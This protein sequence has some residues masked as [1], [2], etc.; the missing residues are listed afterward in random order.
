MAAMAVASATARKIA[1]FFVEA[2]MYEAAPYIDT[3]M[4]MDLLDYFR[5][6]LPSKTTNMFGETASV[7]SESERSL[8]VNVGKG[9]ELEYGLAVSG[10][11]SLLV[12]IE[13]LPTPM[14]DSKV[15]LFGTG[16]KVARRA[17]VM[18]APSDWLTDEGRANIESVEL[19]VPF[20]TASAKFVEDGNKLVFTNTIG[21]YYSDK[22]STASEVARYL[23]PQ[24]TYRFNGKTFVPAK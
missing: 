24:I 23:K 12:V 11:D 3:N 14:P 1:D 9:V 17:S 6:N 16:W 5:S 8:L 4:R 13:T 2:P 19:A 22:D 21:E 18:P 7:V 15:S 10:C 20:I